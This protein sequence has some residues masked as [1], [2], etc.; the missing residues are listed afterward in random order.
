[1]YKRLLSGRLQALINLGKVQ[2]GYPKSGRGRL[3]ERSP[4][5]AFH[6]EVQ[7]T[8]QMGF[9]IVGSN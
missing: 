3:R 9:R 7:V 8:V 5:G 6:C 4:T 1:M 2:L